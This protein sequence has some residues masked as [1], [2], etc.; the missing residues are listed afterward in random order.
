M[1]GCHVSK[2]NSLKVVIQHGMIHEME[3][4]S[5]NWENILQDHVFTKFTLVLRDSGASKE[6]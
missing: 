4:G 2:K 3:L 1:N 6:I 5:K